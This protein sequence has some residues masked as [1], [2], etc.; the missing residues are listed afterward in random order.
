VDHGEGPALARGPALEYSTRVNSSLA[1]QHGAEEAILEVPQAPV[2]VRLV[3]G[4]L[5]L[6][7][8]AEEADELQAGREPHEAGDLEDGRLEHGDGGGEQVP[9]PLEGA[10]LHRWEQAENR[11]VHLE[12]GP[13]VEHLWR[14]PRQS[15][16]FR[17]ISEFI[18]I[19]HEMSPFTM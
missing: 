3:E 16:N 1:A 2:L 11:V 8:A 17:V 10:K 4:V 19:F 15:R 5:Q 7:Q 6:L 9:A 18:L 13:G 14:A 12:H